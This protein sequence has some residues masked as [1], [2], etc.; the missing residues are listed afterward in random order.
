MPKP[1][2]LFAIEKKVSSP[3]FDEW[4]TKLKSVCI[5]I[6]YIQAHTHSQKEVKL[7]QKKKNTQTQTNYT[8]SKLCKSIHKCTPKLQT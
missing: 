2:P 7:P 8:P 4:Q 1:K 3:P 6:Q 5:Y